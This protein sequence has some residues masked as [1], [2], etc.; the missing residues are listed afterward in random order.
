M[1]RWKTWRKTRTRKRKDRQEP[2][3]VPSLWH[4]WDTMHLS[5]PCSSSPSRSRHFFRTEW[6]PARGDIAETGRGGAGYGQAR[7]AAVAPIVEGQAQQQA[8]PP[9]QAC[10]CSTS[11]A[12]AGK[13]VEPGLGLHVAQLGPGVHCQTG[14]GHKGV[15]KEEK[16][17]KRSF[18]QSGLQVFIQLGLLR[19]VLHSVFISTSEDRQTRR[20]QRQ[21]EH[22]RQQRAHRRQA[23]AAAQGAWEHTW[24][25]TKA[26]QYIEE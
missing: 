24:I 15:K 17:T 12:A 20:N 10:P 22:R 13:R 8:P 9:H 19:G 23:I 18:Y 25:R 4:I 11:T 6:E 3:A 1:W 7:V 2:G 26:Q 14:G 5:A 21:L 16:E